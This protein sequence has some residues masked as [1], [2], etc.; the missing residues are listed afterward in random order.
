MLTNK[1]QSIVYKWLNIFGDY[2]MDI[3]V[4][5]EPIKVVV[6]SVFRRFPLIIMVI[7]TFI[8]SVSSAMVISKYIVR[9]VKIF[10]KLFLGIP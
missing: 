10:R 5:A 3:Y 1:N 4:F 8:I 6:R 2:S 7:M 9:N